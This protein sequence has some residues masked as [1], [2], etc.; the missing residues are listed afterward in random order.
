MYI[1]IYTRLLSVYLRMYIY[2]CTLTHTDGGQS[3]P[4]A[5]DNRPGQPGPVD[6]EVGIIRSLQKSCSRNS[7]KGDYIGD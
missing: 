5:T 7:L 1:Y 3:K 2:M 4:Q 6:A